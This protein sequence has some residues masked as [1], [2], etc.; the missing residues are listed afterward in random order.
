MSDPLENVKT[1]VAAIDEAFPQGIPRDTFTLIS[2]EGGTGKSVQLSELLFKRLEAGE[3]GIYICLD[4]M[5]KT[6]MQGLMRFSWDVQKFLDNDKLNFVDC[7][8]FRIKPEK[9]PDW[10]TLI[11]DP[12]D[13]L[14]FANALETLMD[15]LNMHNR[16]IVIIDSLTEFMTLAEPGLLIEAIK[17]WRARGSKERGVTFFASMHFGIGAFEKTVDVFDYIVDGIIDLRY[18]PFFMRQGKLIKQLRVRKMKGAQ[19]STAW[20]P[21][22]VGPNGIEVYRPDAQMRELGPEETEKVLSA[23]LRQLRERKTAK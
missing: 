1:G 16:G 3:P 22:E 7:F 11:K 21:F 17:T 2:G 4:D 14:G 10:V 13:L 8:S 5:P 9:T 12:S 6:I 15:K 19:H 23:M 18:D 20:I